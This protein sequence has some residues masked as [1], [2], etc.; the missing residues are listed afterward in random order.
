MTNG[1]LKNIFTLRW[2]WKKRKHHSNCFCLVH[3]PNGEVHSKSKLQAEQQMTQEEKN[4]RD[5]YK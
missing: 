4:A 1:W 5:M 2:I 3:N